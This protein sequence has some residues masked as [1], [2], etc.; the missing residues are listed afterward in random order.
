MA[1][2]KDK[3]ELTEETL[4]TD[5]AQESVA[6]EE[7]DTDAPTA[8]KRQP[9]AQADTKKPKKRLSR[10]VRFGS[11]AVV[12]TVVVV[13][14]I[15]LLNVLMDV[16]ENRYPI[17]IDLTADK[18]YTLSEDSLKLARQVDKEVQ[19]V[20]FSDESTFSSPNTGTEMYNTL[21]SQFYNTIQQYRLESDGKIAYRFVDLDANPTL[22]SAY[23]QY[24]VSS[25]SI[26]FLCGDRSQVIS[27]NDLYSYEA[28]YTN[29]TVTYSSEVE[30]MVATKVNLVSADVIKT[31]ALLTGHGERE[32]V[33]AGVTT[34]LQ[35]N[36]C[37]V[38]S[39]DMTASQEPSEEV[40]VF[41]LVGPTTDYSAEEI[42][43]LRAWLDNDG[44]REKDLLVFLNYSSRL[45]NLFEMLN[46]QYG[47]E[48][49]DNLVCETDAANESNQNPYYA[50]ADIASTDYTEN[51]TDSRVLSL[52]TRE[53]KLHLTD[54]K[55]ESS[56]SKALVTF[57]ETA[58]VQTL[59]S[60]LGEEGAETGDASLRDADSYP[61]VGAAYT[62]SR[63]YDNN[64]N[65]YY[66]TDV[67]VFGSDLFLFSGVLENVPSAHNE[68]MFLSV[69]RGLTGIESAISISSRSLTQEMLDFGGS[70]VPNVLM[71]VFVI[72][73]PLLLI[74]LAIAVF[75]RRRHL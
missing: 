3:N 71:I 72:V 54:S 13:V 36:G 62:T 25:G 14:A 31:A 35:N 4:K 15:L 74:A 29:Y 17:N 38:T 75:L 61:I 39:L 51:M 69:F 12:T 66:S 10:K 65:C 73:L 24:D 23:Q 49:T 16:L 57:G 7:T 28:D 55:D 22:A 26:L 20:V 67:M 19:I 34:V 59:A 43:R 53:M 58:K 9:A 46:D 42:A 30:R 37:E 18:T 52:F 33:I 1:Q 64:D 41:V 40:S 5:L 47:I 70:L 44:K 68:E 6:Q 32:D 60:A 48:V 45:P 56:Y 63:L 21:L 50:Y 27:V 11:M 2:D 8:D